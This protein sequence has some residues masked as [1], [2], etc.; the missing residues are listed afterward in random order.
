MM[1]GMA[2]AGDEDEVDDPAFVA[3]FEEHYEALV[4]LARLLVDDRGSGEEIVQDAF[5]R[6]YRR[7]SRID[8]PVRYVRAA[9]VNGARSR[10]RHRAV[11]RRYVAPVSRP[12]APVEDE[13]VVRSEHTEVADAVRALPRRQRECLVLRYYADLSEAEI[14]ATLGILTGSVKSHSSRGMAAL[15]RVLGDEA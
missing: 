14:A 11:V 9:V 7:W 5:V 12:A 13:V 15:S 10:L 3:L 4:R 6:V 2:G 8:D 1:A